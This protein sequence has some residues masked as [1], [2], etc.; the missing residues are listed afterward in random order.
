MISKL[1]NP[2]YKKL[3]YQLDRFKA[4]FAV[5]WDGMP[6]PEYT[7]IEVEFLKRIEKC[8]AEMNKPVNKI[9]RK[10]ITKHL[11]FMRECFSTYFWV[12]I[13][14]IFIKKL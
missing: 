1:R 3:S 6:E 10:F 2:P 13:I 11:S 5:A 7:N 9:R 12:K 4:R 8:I 14:K